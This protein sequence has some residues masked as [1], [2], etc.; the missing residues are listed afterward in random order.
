MFTSFFVCLKIILEVIQLIKIEKW[1]DHEIR[2]VLGEDGE[3]WA[4]AKDVA[5]ALGYRDS[6]DMTKRMDQQEIDSF[7]WKKK[8]PEDYAGCFQDFKY[9]PKV[10]II[11]EFGIYE[12]ILNSR[13]KEA[14][15]FKKWVKH[16]LKTL[17]KQSGLEGF[18]VF[19]MMDKE[20]QKKAM[21]QISQIRDAKP[22]HYMKANSIANKV[23][24]DNY[25][26]EKMVKKDEMTPEMLRDRQPVLD[27]TVDLMKVKENLG[28]DVSVKEAVRKKWIKS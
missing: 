2:F 11:S 15:E 12:A 6:N 23:V 13:R 21:E 10:P 18:A 28:L 22:K 5:G 8:Q 14:I 17:R 7:N 24:S 4:V 20:H 9:K 3:W 27:D 25:G 1:L 26:F 16:L 19:R